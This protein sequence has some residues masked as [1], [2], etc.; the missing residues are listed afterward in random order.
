MQKR[1][2]LRCRRTLNPDFF[3]SFCA[4]DFFFCPG[5]NGESGKGPCFINEKKSRQVKLIVHSIY[6]FDLI[7]LMITISRMNI[8]V[9]LIKFLLFDEFEL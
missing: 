8:T 6:H 2:S 7:E 3:F 5:S 9:E 1:I 4:S